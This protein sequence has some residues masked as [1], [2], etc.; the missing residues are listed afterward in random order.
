MTHRQKP[1]S[2]SIL[3]TRRRQPYCPRPRRIIRRDAR[4]NRFQSAFKVLAVSAVLLGA[5]LVVTGGIWNFGTTS[6]FAEVRPAEQ[7]TK[8]SVIVRQ[9]RY[10][11][12]QGVKLG[13][14]AE[15]VRRL[16]PDMVTKGRSA[17]HTGHFL[18]DGVAYSVWFAPGSKPGA[19]YRI[20]YQE[21]FSRLSTN[22]II[23]RFGGEFGQPVVVDCRQGSKISRQGPCHMQWLTREGIKLDV[24][25]RVMAQTRSGRQVTVLSVIATD[26]ATANKLTSL[27]LA[28]RT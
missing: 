15:A 4:R 2:G 7:S 22:N 11:V 9:N 21:S 8:R 17:E 5:A 19:V 20:K 18:A 26:T 13:M 25:S 3:P 6:A 12:V 27:R 23:A 1:F 16:F 24:Y 28:T 14:A 10:F